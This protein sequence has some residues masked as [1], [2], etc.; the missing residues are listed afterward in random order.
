MTTS[1]TTPH[2]DGPALSEWEPWTPQQVS[3]AL[4]DVAVPWAIVGGWAIDLWLDCQ[5][6]KHGDIEI[7]LLR[8][9]FDL[10]RHHLGCSYKLHAAGNGETFALGPSDPLPEATYQCWVLDSGSDKWRLDIMLEPGDPGIWVFRRDARVQRPRSMMISSRGGIRYLR[11]E[12][13]LLYKAKALRDKDQADFDR[14]LQHLGL[15][16]REWLADA[17]AVVHPHHQWIPRLREVM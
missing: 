17:L 6:R 1:H 12:G 8:H 14:C 4:V 3:D 11:P 15:D 7:S 5:S 9:D 10:V 13:V 2:W 16:A